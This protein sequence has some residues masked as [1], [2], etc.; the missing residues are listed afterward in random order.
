MI[1][2]WD[3]VEML[4][5]KSLV[6][7]EKKIKKIGDIGPQLICWI[8]HEWL[9]CI[10]FCNWSFSF[11]SWSFSF[12]ISFCNISFSFCSCFSFSSSSVSLSHATRIFSANSFCVLPTSFIIASSS[13][14]PPTVSCSVLLNLSNVLL[15][16]P[17]VDLRA[18][19]LYSPSNLGGPVRWMY[20]SNWFASPAAPLPSDGGQISS[21]KVHMLS[22]TW[23]KDQT[24]TLHYYLINKWW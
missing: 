24:V 1:Q 10:S 13:T 8:L 11:C 5:L 6:L 9:L 19:D 17:T 23:T 2:T 16:L 3:L 4:T 18:T 21:S 14:T 22:C 15:N 20:W 7:Q 12:C